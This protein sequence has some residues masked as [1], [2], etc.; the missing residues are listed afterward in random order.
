MELGE[1]PVQSTGGGNPLIGSFGEGSRRTHRV[2]GGAVSPVRRSLDLLGRAPSPVR[3][4]VTRPTL[5]IEA[6]EHVFLG[7]R[8]DGSLQESSSSRVRNRPVGPCFRGLSE[9]PVSEDPLEDSKVAWLPAFD[10]WGPHFEW[11]AAL[12]FLPQGIGSH[13]LLH[14]DWLMGSVRAELLSWTDLLLWWSGIEGRG[15][16]DL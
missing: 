5:R 11:G 6:K 16:Y 2:L 10:V 8:S 1:D 9:V 7:V 13:V 15:C 4:S 12:V 3:V 14:V